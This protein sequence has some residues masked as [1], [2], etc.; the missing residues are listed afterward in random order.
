MTTHMYAITF[1]ENKKIII[2]KSTPKPEETPTHKT[3]SLKIFLGT[4]KLI[5]FEIQ[6][7]VFK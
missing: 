6:L 5:Y 7:I 4:L 3:N 2:K 1:V